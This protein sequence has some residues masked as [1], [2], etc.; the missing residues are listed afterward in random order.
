MASAEQMPSREELLEQ[1]ARLEQQQAEKLAFIVEH[2]ES[3]GDRA[4]LAL[5]VVSQ[6]LADCRIDQC[7]CGRPHFAL[8]LDLPEPGT[9]VYRNEFTL[10]GRIITAE[11]CPV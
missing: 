9:V 7:P 3:G 4:E 5:P 11:G 1:I 10:K 8:E 2:V 6:S